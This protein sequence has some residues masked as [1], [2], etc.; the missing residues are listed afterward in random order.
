VSRKQSALACHR[1]QLEPL[2]GCPPILDEAI[3]ERSRW[4]LELFFDV[5]P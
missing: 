1:S 4:P 5:T 3:L 2:E